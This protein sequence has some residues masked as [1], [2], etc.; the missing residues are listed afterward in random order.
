[1]TDEPFFP[2]IT[3]QLMDRVDFCDIWVFLSRSVLVLSPYEY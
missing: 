3:Y 1:M 2:L